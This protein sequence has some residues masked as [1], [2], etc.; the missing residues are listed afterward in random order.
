[1]LIFGACAGFLTVLV[2]NIGIY[3]DGVPFSILLM[4]LANPL[5]DRI[6]PKA[7]GKVAENA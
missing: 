2:R 4:N 1:M 7:I 3:V 5:L 6:R